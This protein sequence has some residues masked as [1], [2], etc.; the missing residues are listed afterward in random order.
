MLCL[1]TSSSASTRARADISACN[2]FASLIRFSPMASIVCG[3]ARAVS[4]SED[5][6]NTNAKRKDFLSARLQS[7]R[8]E[9]AGPGRLASGWLVVASFGKPPFTCVPRFETWGTVAFPQPSHVPAFGDFIYFRNFHPL[10][11]DRGQ[12]LLLGA[13]LGHV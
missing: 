3:E 1:A 8:V 11:L 12:N 10:N 9:K 13:L 4:A 2:L 7:A 5:V 6:H